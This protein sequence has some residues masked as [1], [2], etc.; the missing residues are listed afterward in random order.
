MAAAVGVAG[1]P[2]GA[3]QRADARDFWAAVNDDGATNGLKAQGRFA[4]RLHQVHQCDLPV[5]QR[6]MVLV[7]TNGQQMKA[8][9]LRWREVAIDREV[10][11]DQAGR[12]VHGENW[13]VQYLPE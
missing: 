7:G 10:L 11:L 5:Y 2:W 9:G 3:E 12:D 1:T 4:Q 6:Y 8:A 13:V